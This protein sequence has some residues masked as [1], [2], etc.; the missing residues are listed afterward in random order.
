MVSKDQQIQEL[1]KVLDMTE[2]EQKEWAYALPEWKYDDMSNSLADLAFRMRDKVDK[3]YG[4]LWTGSLHYVY[5]YI[6]RGSLDY[7]MPYVPIFRWFGIKAKPIDWIIA[8]KIAEA[9]NGK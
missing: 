7:E 2:E 6:I 3:A 5:C 8:A 4:L 1:L 9:L